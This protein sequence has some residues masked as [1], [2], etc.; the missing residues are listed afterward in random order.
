MQ[1]TVITPQDL[2]PPAIVQEELET[3]EEYE[4]IMINARENKDNAEERMGIV[5]I[6]AIKKFGR[7]GT[8]KKLAIAA[9]IKKS[10]L[11]GYMKVIKTFDASTRAEFAR[12]PFS[13][14]RLCSEQTKDPERPPI[15][16]LKK[17]DDNNWTWENLKME[18][19]KLQPEKPFDTESCKKNIAK[20]IL[21][22][23]EKAGE[24]FKKILSFLEKILEKFKA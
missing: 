13:V 21:E 17:A 1:K 11:Y 12:V 16:W 5:A 22:A 14:K 7:R 18:I 23:E 4:T 8:V 19:K 3:W 10:T 2:N 15:W 20:L 6:A 24:Q 9:G